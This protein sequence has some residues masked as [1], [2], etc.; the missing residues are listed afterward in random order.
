MVGVLSTSMVL[1]LGALL[2]LTHRRDKR[3][4]N[5]GI[6]VASATVASGRTRAWTGRRSR[7]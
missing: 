4:V 7:R 6:V 5:D 2:M 3:I 1:A